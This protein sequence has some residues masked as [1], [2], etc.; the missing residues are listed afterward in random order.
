MYVIEA[1]HNSRSIRT[2]KHDPVPRYILEEILGICRWIPSGRNIPL[3]YFSVLQDKIQD[4]IN[5]K[6]EEKIITSRNGT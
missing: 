1:I 2:F 5:T 4:E 6:L 3:W